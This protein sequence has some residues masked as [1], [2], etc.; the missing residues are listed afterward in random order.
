MNPSIIRLH[1]RE[2]ARYL[3][4]QRNTLKRLSDHRL[5]TLRASVH[6]GTVNSNIINN[7]V[8][9]LL[10]SAQSTPSVRRIKPV[11]EEMAESYSRGGSS[12]RTGLQRNG[13]QGRGGNRSPSASLPPSTSM[14]HDQPQSNPQPQHHA[15]P[16]DSN[17]NPRFQ[18]SVNRN[19]KT[20]HRPPPRIR[21]THC[22]LLP[23][24][25]TVV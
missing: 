20:N 21:P 7:R 19:S 23:P 17:P 10:T 11:R 8:L 1:Q 25:V 18:N 24:C 14:M 6:K 3:V 13:W 2:H 12:S 15:Q 5:S 9:G 4:P 16:K 22:K